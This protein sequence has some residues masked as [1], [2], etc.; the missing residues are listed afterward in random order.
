MHS[1]ASAGGY[2]VY[3]GWSD[4]LYARV[5]SAYL[6]L[7]VSVLLWRSVALVHTLVFSKGYVMIGSTQMCGKKDA[8]TR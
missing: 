1:W 5:C 4:V 3:E 7:R 2:E 8:A 6:S